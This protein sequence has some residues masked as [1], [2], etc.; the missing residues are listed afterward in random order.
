MPD[1]PLQPGSADGAA[2]PSSS[3]TDTSVVR[4]GYA[5]GGMIGDPSPTGSLGVPRVSPLTLGSI[6]ESLF[7]EDD[8]AVY[9]VLD[10]ASIPD[11]LLTLHEL[12]VDH[13]CL[14]S[15]NIEPDVAHMAPYVVRLSGPRDLLLE[16]LILEGWGHHWC[17]F[18]KVPTSVSFIEAR[19]HFRTLT[20]VRDFTGRL[21]F[22]R[23]YDPRVCRRYLPTCTPEELAEFMGP[24]TAVICEDAAIQNMLTWTAGGSPEPERFQLPIRYGAAPAKASP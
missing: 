1:Q 19:R 22:F 11:M 6:G 17:C 2:A 7:A 9:A 4:S 21:L 10:G 20:V 12:G 14:L 23:F 18:Y 13:Q 15:G 8:Q 3:G 24:C 5:S 16:H